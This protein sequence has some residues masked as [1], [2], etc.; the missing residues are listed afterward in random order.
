MT[1]S[2][3]SLVSLFLMAMAQGAIEFGLIVNSAVVTATIEPMPAFELQFPETKTPQVLELEIQI[4]PTLMNVHPAPPV[5][6]RIL[7]SAV[8]V[9]G[10]WLM[11]ACGLIYFLYRRSHNLTR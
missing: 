7:I 6:T 11:L 2:L 8:I 3:L 1:F 10:L 5:P 9:I 4:Q